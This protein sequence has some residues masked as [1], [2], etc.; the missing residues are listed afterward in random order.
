MTYITRDQAWIELARHVYDIQ[1]KR[2]E[3]EKEEKRLLEELKTKSDNHPAKGG[4]FVFQVTFRKGSIDYN[5]IPELKQVN[6]ELYR[7]EE[8]KQWNLR[9]LT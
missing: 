2:K 6:L 3:L 7:K 9:C 1:Q 5:A 4:D 8:V